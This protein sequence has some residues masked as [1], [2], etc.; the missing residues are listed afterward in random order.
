MWYYTKV[1]GIKLADKV[2][3]EHVSEVMRD[4]KDTWKAVRKDKTGYGGTP[5]EPSGITDSGNE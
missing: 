1:F 3:K 5:V 2:T 4:W